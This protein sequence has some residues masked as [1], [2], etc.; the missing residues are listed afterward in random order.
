MAMTASRSPHH[1][2]EDD[3]MTYLWVALG[4]ALGGMARYWMSE[5]VAVAIG[6]TFPWGTL[7]INI[8]GSLIIGFFATYTGPDGR[9]LIPSDIRIF[10]MVGICGG[11]TTFSSFSLQTLNLARSGDFMR[12]GM[13]VILSVAL[14]LLFVWLGHLAASALNQIKS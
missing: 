14:C 9:I 11:F 12:A 4:S 5:V 13:N 7:V 2:Q 6:E 3:S 1:A 10:V 8:I